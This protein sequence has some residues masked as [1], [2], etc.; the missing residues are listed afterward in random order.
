MSLLERVYRRTHKASYLTAI[1][2]ALK[3]LQTPV[4]K[5]GLG[6]SFD[7]GIYFEEYPTRTIN[8]SLNGDLQTLIGIY[9]AADLVPAAQ[10]LFTRAV[11]TVADNIGRF[12]SH[13]GY[14]YYSLGVADAVPSGLQRCNQIRAEHP[15]VADRTRVFTHYARIWTAP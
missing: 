3:P 5:G 4:T 10:T 6:R 7:N 8:F 1:E 11:R 15:R 9:D 2:R 13:A 14:S 12:D